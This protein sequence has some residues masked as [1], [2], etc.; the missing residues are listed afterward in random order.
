MENIIADPETNGTVF[1]REKETISTEDESEE[2]RRVQGK[3]GNFSVTN[4]TRQIFMKRKR[5]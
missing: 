2:S 3:L 4:K 1:E 5:K